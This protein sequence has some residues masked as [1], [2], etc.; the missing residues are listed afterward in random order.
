[1]LELFLNGDLSK[2]IEVSS[3]FKD[4]LQSCLFVDPSKRKDS[5]TLLHHNLF[6]HLNKNLFCK[7]L[8][9]ICPVD[10]DTLVSF[11]SKDEIRQKQSNS[12]DNYEIFKNIFKIDVLLF[13]KKKGII[14]YKPMI[15]KIPSYFRFNQASTIETTTVMIQNSTKNEFEKLFDGDHQNDHFYEGNLISIGNYI[16][17]L[18]SDYEKENLLLDSFLKNSIFDMQL[19]VSDKYSSNISDSS[20]EISAK[21]GVS[22]KSSDSKLI[23]SKIANNEKIKEINYYFK[24]KYIIRNIITQTNVFKKDE[25]LSE[26]KKNGYYI[27]SNFRATIYKIILEADLINDNEV[28]ETT[29]LYENH[30]YASKEMKQ[31]LVKLYNFLERHSEVRG[32]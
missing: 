29:S 27:P 25:L 23:T 13:L 9:Y 19:I 28:T 4:F 26:I 6:A 3:D 1:M 16:I 5:A 21:D 17:N 18:P 20:S 8:Y 32:L 31:I 10:K 15:L 12:I 11:Y 14:D 30:S 24:L 7:S 22:V 2:K